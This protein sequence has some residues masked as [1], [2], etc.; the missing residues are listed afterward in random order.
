MHKVCWKVRILTLQK[1]PILWDMKI[2]FILVDYSASRLVFPQKNIEKLELRRG[3]YG[4]N[5]F[6]PMHR[7]ALVKVLQF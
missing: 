1:L 2:R 3:N 6:V 7:M 4:I 5:C